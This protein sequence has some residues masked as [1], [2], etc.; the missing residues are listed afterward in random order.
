MRTMVTHNDLMDAVS[1]LND[2]EALRRVR[3]DENVEIRSSTYVP[4]R[5]WIYV[6]D[7]TRVANPNTDATTLVLCHP[8]DHAAVSVMV[9]ELRETREHEVRIR[10]FDLRGDTWGYDATCSCG[11][12]GAPHYGEGSHEAAEAEAEE[13]VHGQS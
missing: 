11:W 10:F 1:R 7:M 3:D 13:H 5:G 8:L 6:M 4:E 9:E 12:K 2:A